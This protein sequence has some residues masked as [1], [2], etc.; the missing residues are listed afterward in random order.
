MRRQLRGGHQSGSGGQASEPRQ[1]QGSRDGQPGAEGQPGNSGEVSDT[2]D[3]LTDTIS[4]A[5][6]NSVANEATAN[7]VT[8]RFIVAQMTDT[9]YGILV[10][11]GIVV[12]VHYLVLL[13]WAC[14]KNRR[15]ERWQRTMTQEHTDVAVH[16]SVCHS[17]SSAKQSYS[18]VDTHSGGSVI[19]SVMNASAGPPQS[20]LSSNMAGA[21]ETDIWSAS[22][23]PTQ[24]Y[25]R[26][27][28]RNTLEVISRPVSA[29][30][31]VLEEIELEPL[32]SRPL[33]RLLRGPPAM[34]V[35]V[36]QVAGLSYAWHRR[37]RR[38][39]V[40]RALHH[41]RRRRRPTSFIWL[42]SRHYQQ[43]SYGLIQRS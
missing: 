22:T 33:H 39:P 23:F 1:L 12:F 19:R 3:T 18:D 30:C 13:F 36:W 38:G 5:S 2:R 43:P 6:N 28:H 7:T 32:L 42:S 37:R 21:K 9:I 29:Q 20:R 4:V 34:C 26:G 41:R 17:R 31:G 8:V 10:I 25:P 24:Q 40:G 16:R 15:H 11:Q 35:G 14:C 27:G